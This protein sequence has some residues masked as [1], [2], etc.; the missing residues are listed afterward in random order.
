MA[1]LLA[2]FYE[3]NKK[4][5][6][7][8]SPKIFPAAFWSKDMTIGSSLVS[9]NFLRAEVENSPSKVTLGESNFLKS[10]TELA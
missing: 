2:S 6:G 10:T 8:L 5:Q 3:V 7:T 1:D 9:M 4:R